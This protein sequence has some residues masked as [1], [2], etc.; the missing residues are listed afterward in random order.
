MADFSAFSES[1]I[2]ADAVVLHADSKVASIGQTNLQLRPPRMHVGVADSLVA[3]SIDLILN[4]GMHFFRGA[5][6]RKRT[7][8]GTLRTTFFD[9]SSK[10]FGQVILRCG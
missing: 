6:D 1:W 8:H 2:N 9:G 5:Q 3:N 4:N 7:L 10:S